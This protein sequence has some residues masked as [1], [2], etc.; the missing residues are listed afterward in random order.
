[1]V[2]SALPVRGK[3]VRRDICFYLPIQIVNK[4]VPLSGFTKR[5]RENMET[6]LN[7]LEVIHKEAE[8]IDK[9]LPKTLEEIF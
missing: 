2:R 9:I 5:L 3:Q 4:I 7:Y 1:V 8:E 6:T